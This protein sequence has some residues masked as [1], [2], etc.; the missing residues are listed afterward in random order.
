MIN[1]LPLIIVQEIDV[2]HTRVFIKT[3]Y[4]RWT[5]ANK[6]FPAFKI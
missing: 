5:F 1:A 6:Q 4:K 2:L 3:L